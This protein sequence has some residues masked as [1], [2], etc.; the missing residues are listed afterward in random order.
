MTKNK[1][2]EELDNLVSDYL[3]FKTSSGIRRSASHAELESYLLAYREM[4]RLMNLFRAVRIRYTDEEI[5]YANLVWEFPKDLEVANKHRSNADFIWHNPR[6]AAERLR[7]G[8]N[9]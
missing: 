4:V 6:I 7:A 8:Q 3:G 9:V 5:L 2:R 1:M